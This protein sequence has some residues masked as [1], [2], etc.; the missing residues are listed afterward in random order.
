[1]PAAGKAE[2]RMDENTG[3]QIA[4]GTKLIKE[5]RSARDAQTPG[6]GSV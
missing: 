2:M 1:M 3:C 6:G 5:G 4:C